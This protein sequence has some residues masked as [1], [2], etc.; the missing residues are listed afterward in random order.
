MLFANNPNKIVTS[1][2]EL[3]KAAT[4]MTFEIL[5]VGVP[6]SKNRSR[7]KPPTVIPVAMTKWVINSVKWE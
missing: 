5:F 7:K 3:E 4:W 2:R 1:Q 6:F